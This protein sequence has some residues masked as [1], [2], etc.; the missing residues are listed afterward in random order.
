M[1]RFEKLTKSD[2]KTISH[3]ICDKILNAVEDCE[4]CP[5]SDKCGPG[6]NGFVEYLLEEVQDGD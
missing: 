1:T 4:G 2:P 5:F 6:H 3:E